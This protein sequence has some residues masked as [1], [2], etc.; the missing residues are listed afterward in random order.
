MVE[1]WNRQVQW[2]G[3]PVN[4]KGEQVY[5]RL[6]VRQVEEVTATR[7]AIWGSD[8]MK[9]EADSGG[10]EEVELQL[11]NEKSGD[12]AIMKDFAKVQAQLCRTDVNTAV[13][14]EPIILICQIPVDF[15]GSISSGSDADSLSTGSNSPIFYNDQDL[16]LWSTLWDP[17]L[18]SEPLKPLAV[19][20]KSLHEMSNKTANSQF[21]LINRLETWSAEVKSK[22]RSQLH[23]LTQRVKPKVRSPEQKKLEEDSDLV[24]EH[25]QE[26]GFSDIPL[27]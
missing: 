4:A 22:F 27:V 3:H 2:K 13:L 26:D 10:Y 15:S 16:S 8:A 20:P 17:A 6:Q 5:S 7:E 19:D 23:Q 11:T 14:S 12:F 9:E 1:P 21:K 18:M 25:K 24:E